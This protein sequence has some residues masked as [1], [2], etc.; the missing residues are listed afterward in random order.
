MKV[1]FSFIYFNLL[2]LENACRMEGLKNRNRG[3]K[4]S[5]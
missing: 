3:R 4:G 1:S 2:V 5:I